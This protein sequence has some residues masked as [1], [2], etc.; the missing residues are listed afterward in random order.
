MKDQHQLTVQE[1]LSQ[2]FGSYKA[3]W[4]KEQLYELFTE[5]AYFP[6][7]KT[8]RSCVL[9]GGRG[10]GKTTVLRGLSYMG[11]YAL[12]QPKDEDITSWQHFGIYYRVNTNHVTAFN[13]ELTDEEW[14]PLF[15]HYVNLLLCDLLLEFVEWFEL[16]SNLRVEFSQTDVE[17]FA[18]S[19][20]LPA[21]KNHG[22]IRIAL[23]DA[24]IAFEAYINNVVDAD[25]PPL[26]MQAAPIDLL[27]S[28]I[29]KFESFDGT[30][31]FF[32]IDEYEN[33]L[34]YQQKV[35]NTLVKHAS[36]RYCFKIGVKELGQRIRATLNPH[37]QLVH[38]ADYARIDIQEK[39][40]GEV[41]RKFAVSVCKSRLDRIEQNGE[42][43]IADLESAFENLDEDQE[44]LKLGIKNLSQPV[45]ERLGRISQTTSL[46]N[47]MMANMTPLEIYFVHFWAESQK[48]PEL[49]VLR[50]ACSSP[51]SWKTRFLNYKHSLLYTIRRKK[52]GIRKYYCGWDTLTRLSGGNIRYFLELVDQCLVKQY[53][54]DGKLELPISAE[55]QTKVA[56]DVGNMNLSELE[57]LSVNGAQLTKM[58]LSLGRVFQVM[59]SDASGHT[60]E[61]NQFHLCQGDA[62]NQLDNDQS[63]KKLIDSAVMH[64]ALIRLRGNKPTGVGDTKDY[65]YM[66]HPIFSALFVVSLRKKRKVPLSD[67][68]IFGLV[69]SPQKTINSILK[70]SERSQTSD[71][72]PE[73]LTL[74]KRFY[75]ANPQ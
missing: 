28:I 59:A 44:A 75:D 36:D 35:F 20:H 14:I 57:G 46:E 40:E 11:Q 5:P 73:Q 42:R 63:V 29:Q 45:R 69:N 15:S 54:E 34:D 26:S 58:V 74:F 16:R 72:L 10:T 38:P 60:P 49:Q 67:E 24:K 62:S 50:E 41:F 53:R 27:C 25:R 65:V 70:R 51:Q 66:L 31:F 37:E 71:D 4:L 61:V 13:G 6:E 43:L 2:V 8:T 39:L 48:K 21:C 68:D 30:Q 23:T 19:L 12:R 18:S 7:L 47:E 9:I 22:E 33:L 3:E 32:L 64:L 17:R 1:Q 52:A 55:T 56:Q